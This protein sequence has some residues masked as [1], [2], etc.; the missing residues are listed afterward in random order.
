MYKVGYEHQIPGRHVRDQTAPHPGRR[1]TWTFLLAGVW[2]NYGVL[3]GQRSG[4]HI[5]TLPPEYFSGVFPAP[6][7][8]GLY[9][10]RL[11]II[12]N[13][14][15]GARYTYN[16]TICSVLVV[17]R[18]GYKGLQCK[19]AFWSFVDRVND[20][21]TR[22]YITCT[23]TYGHTFLGRCKITTMCKGLF[24]YYHLCCLL[25]NDLCNK[26]CKGMGDVA[27]YNRQNYNQLCL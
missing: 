23:S 18:H 11:V 2:E 5:G 17:H 19:D 4:Q 16:L 25:R 24:N 9:T 7:E 21:F 15:F 13:E 12:A 26:V 6:R 3:K 8:L 14:Y 1:G 10:S 22:L 27:L 20:F